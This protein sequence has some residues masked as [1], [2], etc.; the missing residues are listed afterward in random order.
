[1]LAIGD[2]KRF[3]GRMGRP[4]E[5]TSKFLSEVIH[6]QYGFTLVPSTYCCFK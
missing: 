4:N 1:M 5:Q 3:L 6:I 2:P